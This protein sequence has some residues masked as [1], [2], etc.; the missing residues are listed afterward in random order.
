MELLSARR[1]RAAVVRHGK[2]LHELSLLQA[3]RDVRTLRAEAREILQ[4]E[5]L[6]SV[7]P[8]TATA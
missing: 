4:R 5:I 3:R 7:Q 6:R 1:V 2:M 8:R